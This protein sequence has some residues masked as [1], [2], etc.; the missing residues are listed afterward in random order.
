MTDKD[1]FKGV[2]YDSLNKQVDGNHYQGMKIQPAQ[3]IN[4]NHLEFA[5]GNAI[6]YICRHK[7]KGK[8]KDLLK[9]KHYIDMIIERDY[10]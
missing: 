4:E 3:F 9:A 6:K 1:M 5:E 10:S 7:K 2:T 8:E